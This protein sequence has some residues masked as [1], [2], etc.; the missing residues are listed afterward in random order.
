M[1]PELAQ[2]LTWLGS[3]LLGGAFAAGGAWAVMRVDLR[4]LSER[5]AHLERRFDTLEARLFQIVSRG[6]YDPRD[7]HAG[8][9]PPARP[10]RG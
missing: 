1:T 4:S 8:P 2:F 10:G 5:L 6:S 3:V 7:H 9:R